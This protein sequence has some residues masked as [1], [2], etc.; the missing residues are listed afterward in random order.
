MI[1]LADDDYATGSIAD[2]PSNEDALI[3][4]QFLQYQD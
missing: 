4:S 2:L 1:L 3:N